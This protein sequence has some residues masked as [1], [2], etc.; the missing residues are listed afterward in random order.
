MHD[1]TR[2]KLGTFGHKSRQSVAT[3]PLWIG[4]LIIATALS[5]SGQTELPDTA[6]RILSGESQSNQ[7]RPGIPLAS[8]N[9]DGKFAFQVLEQLC[10]IGPRISGTPGM[11]T[12]Q[13]FLAKHFESL[14]ATIGWQPFQGLHPVHQ[15]PV[16]FRNLLVQ[17]HPDRTARIL[18]ACHF[19]TRP[20][21]DMD[22][23]N[24][25]GVF[26]GANDG[27]SGVGLL[28]ELGQF[29]PALQSDY[30]VDFVFFDAEEFVFQKGRDPY[31]LGSTHFANQYI[32]TPPPWRYAAGVLVDMIGD[33]DLNI[34]LEVNSWKSSREITR[35]IWDVA[36]RMGV[37][38]FIPRTRHE[39]KDDH[40]PLIN[41]AKIPTCDIIDFDYPSPADKQK[42]RYWHTQDDTPDK[43][44]A[45]SLGKVGNVLL[46][47]LREVRMKK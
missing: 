32:A 27:A 36:Q 43:C 10:K 18:I 2:I 42:N 11:T 1:T 33:K 4:L 20:F 23:T 6:D 38:E 13:E 40:L 8:D 26:L 17:F 12:Q 45:E 9:L 19:D 39:V 15:T 30:G 37:K 46:G 24:P 47:W 14:G 31:F 28:C 41:I 34:Y 21:P 25:T 29:M 3:V 22:R 16:E 35:Q 5:C 7:T 44:S